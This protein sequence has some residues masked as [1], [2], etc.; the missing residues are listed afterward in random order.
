MICNLKDYLSAVTSTNCQYEDNKI[1]LI[2]YV[3]VLMRPNIICLEELKQ[4]KESS[5]VK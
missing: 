5:V 3:V 1:K 4:L 2:L